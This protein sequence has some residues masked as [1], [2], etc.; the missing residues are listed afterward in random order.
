M[1]T[2]NQVEQSSQAA[3]QQK[4]VPIANKLEATV[5]VIDGFGR[6]KK[7]SEVTIRFANKVV[8]TKTLGGEYKPTQALTE[9]KR[10]QNGWSIKDSVGLEQARQLKLL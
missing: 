1:N 4:A 3:E 8:A 5:K 9:F 7:A 10:S 6:C 2:E